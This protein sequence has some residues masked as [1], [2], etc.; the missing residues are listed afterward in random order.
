MKVPAEV[1]MKKQKPKQAFENSKAKNRKMIRVGE[2]WKSSL[3]P[4]PVWGIILE[5]CDPIG[6]AKLERVCRMLFLLVNPRCGCTEIKGS[7]SCKSLWRKFPYPEGAK[8]YEDS[9]CAYIKRVILRDYMPLVLSKNIEKVKNISCKQNAHNWEVHPE[10]PNIIRCPSCHKGAKRNVY[11]PSIC[12]LHNKMCLNEYSKFVVCRSHSCIAC[13]VPLVFP[14]VAI[15]Q[16][17]LSE[18]SS[19]TL[20][21]AIKLVFSNPLD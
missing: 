1:L 2:K 21:P 5:F 9:N 16:Q 15:I 6:I 17:I 20:H 10:N 3:I 14:H 12:Q 4:R 11:C 18:C 19:Y 7:S 8:K 13:R